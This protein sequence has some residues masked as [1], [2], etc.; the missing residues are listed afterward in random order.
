M[1]VFWQD[2]KYGIRMAAKSPGLTIAAILSVALGIGANSTVFTW[3]QAFMFQPLPG[4]PEQSRIVSMSTSW[5][6][7]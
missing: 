7:G 2:V 3:A 4:V 1:G 6:D 5:Q